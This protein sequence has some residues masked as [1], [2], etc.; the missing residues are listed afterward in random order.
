MW[1]SMTDKVLMA[2]SKVRLAYD[3]VWEPWQLPSR[4]PAVLKPAGDL[5]S[6]EGFRTFDPHDD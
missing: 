4:L 1:Q 6:L 2:I 5:R 3:R